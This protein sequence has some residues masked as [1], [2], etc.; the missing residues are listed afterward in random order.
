MPA[1]SVIVPIYNG[2]K[3][4]HR[5][6][7]SVLS[8]TFDDFELILVDDGSTDSCG[9]ICD[10]YAKK[11][12]RVVVLHSVNQGVSLARNLGLSVA[13][14]EYVAFCDGD[15]FYKECMIEHTYR[16][17]VDTGAEVVSYKLQRISDYNISDNHNDPIEIIDLDGDNRF[18]FLYKVV[19]WQT[20][21][22]Q[23]CR[24]IFK[25]KYIED[26][27]ILFCG[28]C[29]N[30]AEDLGFTL[31]YLL[32]TNRIVFLDEYL[33]CYYDVRQDS[34]MNKSKRVYKINE[35]NEL[36][37]YLKP[38]M[39]EVLTEDQFSQI[40]YHIINNQ[41]AD[42]FSS[43][44]ISE[45]SDWCNRLKTVNKIR[46]FKEHNAMYY[47]GII[48]TQLKKAR[49]STM[50]YYLSK[51]MIITRYLGTFNKFKLYSDIMINRLLSIV[52]RK[53]NK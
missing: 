41:V 18:D 14:G 22:W 49:H 9:R 50:R 16:T 5:C 2:E 23:A 34:M 32:Y 33:Y 36:S 27:R 29:G 43:T 11:D 35:V 48:K 25:R 1:V 40:H 37:Y 4:I 19:T 38:I 44:T 24:S 10:E 21:G 47:D 52:Y 7:D 42:M 20:K 53:N 51:R 3:Y 28:T 6:V 12:S 30:F 39:K 15:D 46:Y 13:R 8:Q 31:E 26:K 45:L 17:A